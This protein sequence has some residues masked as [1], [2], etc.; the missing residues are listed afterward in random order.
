MSKNIIKLL[1]GDDYDYDYGNTK[2]VKYKNE[3]FLEVG[4]VR[5]SLRCRYRY[6]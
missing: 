5:M 6:F 3:A 2:E 1:L 4:R